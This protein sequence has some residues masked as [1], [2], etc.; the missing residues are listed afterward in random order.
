MSLY[1]SPAFQKGLS[2]VVKTM[3]FA[4]KKEIAITPLTSPCNK[5]HYTLYYFSSISPQDFR[6]VL[7]TKFRDR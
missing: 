6:R 1:K 5:H 2:R 7:K 3:Y 4:M